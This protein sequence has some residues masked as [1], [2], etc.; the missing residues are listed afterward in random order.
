MH[1]RSMKALKKELTRSLQLQM[2]SLYNLSN[3]AIGL[4]Y[5]PF[6]LGTVMGT[7]IG[8]KVQSY[9]KMH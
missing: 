3:F 9:P 5:L 8:G 7:I 6:G 1:E 4:T 2:R